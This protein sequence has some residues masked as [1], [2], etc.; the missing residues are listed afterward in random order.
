MGGVARAPKGGTA[1][2]FCAFMFAWAGSS[3]EEG[4]VEVPL[5]AMVKVRTLT[6][7]KEAEME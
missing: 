1:V 2:L 6:G 3:D 5:C 7:Y 4:T